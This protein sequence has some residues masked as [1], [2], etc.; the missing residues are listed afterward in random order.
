MFSLCSCKKPHILAIILHT[1]DPIIRKVIFVTLFIKNVLKYIPFLCSFL[2]SLKHNFRGNS[3]FISIGKSQVLFHWNH[4]ATVAE[5]SGR[6][7]CSLGFCIITV[8]CLKDLISGCFMDCDNENFSQPANFQGELMKK[9]CTNKSIHLGGETHQLQRKQDPSKWR[10]WMSRCL[11][12]PAEMQV[13]LPAC[14]PVLQPFCGWQSPAVDHGGV[15]WPLFHLYFHKPY[16][17]PL[18]YPL[19]FIPKK[20]SDPDWHR[21]LLEP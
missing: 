19:L 14:C 15:G 17:S 20:P 7:G 5:Q 1:E 13:S 9:I 8:D 12:G 21:T 2:C 4:T 6:A 11:L 16:W 3:N 10:E 18:P